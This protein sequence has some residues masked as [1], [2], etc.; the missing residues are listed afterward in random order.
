MRYR[1]RG[2]AAVIA[3][4]NFPLAIPCGM[5]AAALAAGN[6]AVLKPAE[7]SPGQRACTGGG[8][9]R[10]RECR[11]TRWRWC[12]ATERPALRS[13]ATRECT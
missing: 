13:C 9:P 6:A 7:Q 5:T 2:V 10:A 11:T 12:R 8:P 3:P 1:P 4:W